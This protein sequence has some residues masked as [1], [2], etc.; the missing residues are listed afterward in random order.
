M[1]SGTTRSWGILIPLVV[2]TNTDRPEELEQP[3]IFS[4]IPDSGEKRPVAMHNSIL[5]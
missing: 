4:S 2:Y 3:E 5:K 1:L